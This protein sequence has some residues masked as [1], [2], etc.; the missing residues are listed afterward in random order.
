MKKD[1]VNINI[2]KSIL[3]LLYDIKINLNVCLLQEKMQQ[4]SLMR[5]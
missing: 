5:Q 2:F 1:M 3:S 4:E